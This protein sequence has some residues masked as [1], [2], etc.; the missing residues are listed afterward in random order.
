[1]VQS[2]AKDSFTKEEVQNYEDAL[3]SLKYF[4]LED[5]DEIKVEHVDTVYEFLSHSTNTKR[6]DKQLF[7]HY[8]QDIPPEEVKKMKMVLKKLKK[9]IKENTQGPV[10]ESKKKLIEYGVLNFCSAFLTKPLLHE[11][12]EMIAITENSLKDSEMK[13]IINQ[14][15]LHNKEPK[16][17]DEWL[18]TE[19][20]QV[21]T[22]LRTADE[23][24]ELS[25][26]HVNKFV[27][28][29][30]KYSQGRLLFHINGYIQTEETVRIY[31][32]PME[33]TNEGI[34]PLNHPWKI[35]EWSI[36]RN[37]IKAHRVAHLKQNDLVLV[38]FSGTQN[39]H[40]LA[41]L[42]FIDFTTAEVVPL[43]LEQSLQ[44]I[45]GTAFVKQLKDNMS[46]NTS[47]EIEAIIIQRL[48]NVNQELKNQLE[49][50]QQEFVLQQQKLSEEQQMWRRIF[51]KIEQAIAFEQ[52]EAKVDEV[53]IHPYKEET[54]CKQVQSLLYHNDE[55]QLIYQESTLKSFIHALQANV[56]TILT[57]PSGTGKSSIV[58]AFGHAVQNV[59]V[60]MIP[61]QSSWTDTQD[62]IGYFH[63]TDKTF[64]PTPFMEALAEA[65]KNSNKLFLI[66]LDEMNL[67]HVEY[68]FSELLSAR[69]EKNPALRLYA[70][71]HYDI[72]KIICDQGCEDVE[73][74][75]N[76]QELIENYQSTFKIPSNVRFIGTLNMDHTVKP[77]SPKVIDRSFIIEINHLS[78][79]QKQKIIDTISKEKLTGKIEMDATI[80]STVR[81][82]EESVKKA[83][84]ILEDISST[85][86]NYPNA[87]LNSRG[88]KHLRKMLQFADLEETSLTIY[89]DS[90][91]S[92]KILPRIDIPKV[93]LDLIT[94]KF[95]EKLSNY[96]VSSQKFEKMLATN[97]MVKFW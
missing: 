13:T 70:K 96:P 25:A 20:A 87:S 38:N 43:S 64:V 33:W 41:S 84:N 27:K 55:E 39:T 75:R 45:G 90:L 3:N 37:N 58:Q 94:Q 57:G 60:R 32:T 92:G 19:A 42:L 59:A 29:F 69:E 10:E 61:V 85:L 82:D 76:A 54:F 6:Q 46:V 88:Y 48:L 21:V 67:A 17:Y 34:V 51:Y 15:Q 89:I 35:E 86:N 28:L 49:K 1:M 79:I 95:V 31:G 30:K 71:R 24:N 9:G 23:N 66:C 73:R 22:E 18:S 72:A 7:A 74:L 8:L 80:F 63:P 53:Q 93:D 78:K 36:S 77:L 14:T 68:Y 11:E 4:L 56:L 40:F 52:K 97:R 50:E 44:E 12:K 65:S 91:I 16:R 81:N 2:I 47:E 83:V 26:L 62:L 5:N